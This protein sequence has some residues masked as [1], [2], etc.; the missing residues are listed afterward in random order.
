MQMLLGGLS[1]RDKCPDES[2]RGDSDR[3]DA[4]IALAS[5][6]AWTRYPVAKV[7][8]AAATNTAARC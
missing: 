5:P 8:N 3:G 4:Q 6:N 7:L 1:L 2:G